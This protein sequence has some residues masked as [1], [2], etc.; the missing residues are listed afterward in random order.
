MEPT[1]SDLQAQIDRLSLVVQQG[2][3]SKTT[4]EPVA[5]QLSLLTERCAEILHRLTESDERRT[6]ALGE[7]EARLSAQDWQ[8]LRQLH[9]EPVKQLREQA[10]ALGEVCVS[11]ANLALQGF[12]RAEA[13]V[14][15][16]ET[17]LQDQ[18]KQLSRDLQAA[19]TDAR[20]ALP[21][22][23][24]TGAGVAPFPLEGVMRLHE[25]LRGSGDGTAV[26]E[27]GAPRQLPEATALLSARMESLEREVTSE[28]EDVRETATRADRMRRDWRVTVA[29]VGVVL[30]IGA[31][32]GV[33]VNQRVN[34]RLDE[35]ATRV[36]AAQQQAQNVSD[37]ATQQ[38]A[39]A[40][41]EA[42]RQISEA[43]QTAL[44]AEVVGNVL[45]APDLVR[46]NLAGTERAPRASA[47][48]LYSRSRGLVLS[49][50][51]LPVPPAG[52]T[53]QIWLMTDA[54]PV[55]GGTFAPDTAGRATFAIDT[56]PV[57]TR[58][59]TSVV[60]T[61]ESAGAQTTPVGVPVLK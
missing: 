20:R 2:R 24:G 41:L 49:A 51:F 58:T 30:V 38:I 59:V 35:A 53:Y 52:G 36:A 50:S 21:P 32:V 16:L 13:R 60:V 23:G 55:S 25:E 3:E 14:A 5:H 48:V 10:A 11:A 29:V 33:V 1:T 9:E 7:V 46:F 47:Q 44:K 8:V 17:S 61:L 19:T 15:A 43:R 27:A 18:L 12:E 56:P 54:A 34:T 6:Q 57:I 39:A 26:A 37:A 4:L 28:R 45:A 40:R 22:A 42:E 31:I